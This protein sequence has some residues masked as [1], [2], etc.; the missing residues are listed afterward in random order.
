MRLE[1]RKK[2]VERRQAV[3]KRIRRRIHGTAER[4]RLSVF[5]SNRHLHLQLIDDWQGHTLASLS[6]EEKAFKEEGFSHGGTVP[7]AAA[8]GRLLAE[9]AKGAGVRRVVFDRGGYDYHGRV[10]AAAE[11]AREAGLEF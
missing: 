6:T 7:A 5:R 3:R 11:A 2:K 1:R 10:K 8:A 9:R 4:P